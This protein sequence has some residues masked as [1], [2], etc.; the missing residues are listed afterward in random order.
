M[1]WDHFD[2]GYT[3]Q[4][5]GTP[6]NILDDYRDGSALTFAESLRGDLLVVHDLIDDNVHFPAH[7]VA[8][9]GPHRRRK[10]YETLIYPN[11]RH[12]APSE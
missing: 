4:Y 10:L 3:E 6:Q 8:D 12:P 11:E 7:L 9:P 2:S 1:P 5:M